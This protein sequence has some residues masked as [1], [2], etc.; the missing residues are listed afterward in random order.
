MV[1]D[2]MQ[3]CSRV[4]NTCPK[5]AVDTLPTLRT[6]GG[7][8]IMTAQCRRILQRGDGPASATLAKHLIFSMLTRWAESRKQ[9]AH[10]RKHRIDG[11]RSLNGDFPFLIAGVRGFV[12][13]SAA[14]WGND[15]GRRPANA[16]WRHGSQKC[17]FGQ[18]RIFRFDMLFARQSRKE[19]A[20][21]L[22]EPHASALLT[23]KQACN[24]PWCCMLS[25]LPSH[26][27]IG[28]A[29]S[30]PAHLPSVP[31]ATPGFL[32][33]QLTFMGIKD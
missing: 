27:I 13:R 3:P 15:L 24:L 17:Q 23:V 21:N 16:K 31:N 11:A 25:A 26:A 2:P 22:F 14:E 12:R 9:T 19:A 28:S 7:K 10:V 4:E 1:V 33:S 32:A 6:P 29:S 30:P 8:G 5:L 18:I 20:R